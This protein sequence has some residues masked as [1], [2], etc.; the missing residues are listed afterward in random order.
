MQPHLPISCLPPPPHTKRM[1]SWCSGKGHF[2]IPSQLSLPQQ[3]LYMVQN[4]GPQCPPAHTVSAPFSLQGVSTPPQLTARE[5]QAGRHS[6]PLLR[7]LFPVSTAFLSKATS[8]LGLPCSARPLSLHAWPPSVTAWIPLPSLLAACFSLPA[9]LRDQLLPSGCLAGAVGVP[10]G[11]SLACSPPDSSPAGKPGRS[12][13]CFCVGCIS[14]CLVFR[15]GFL[16]GAGGVQRGQIL[17]LGIK[18]CAWERQ[19]EAGWGWPFPARG[20]S[21]LPR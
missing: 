14:F 8:P 17:V 16:F 18:V 21:S 20:G 10:G 7:W 1:S 11:L 15:W 4:K 13:S 5:R 6:S 12:R 3:H 2:C 9:P 19:L